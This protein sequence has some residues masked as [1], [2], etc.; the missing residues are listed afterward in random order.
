MNFLGSLKLEPDLVLSDYRYLNSEFRGVHGESGGL[1]CP[2]WLPIVTLFIIP[3]Y[4][5]VD[6]HVTFVISNARNPSC[7]KK[8]II[9][10]NE[11]SIIGWVAPVYRISPNWVSVNSQTADY[12]YQKNYGE[13]AVA[14][15]MNQAQDF[16]E[17]VNCN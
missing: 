14:Q 17:V 11:K 8:L 9:K 6:Y 1:L 3:M 13:Y 2:P 5:N 7:S 10:R 12:D 4:C 16:T 15:V